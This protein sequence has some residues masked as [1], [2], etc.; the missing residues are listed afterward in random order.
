MVEPPRARSPLPDLG[1]IVEHRADQAGI[2]DAAMA[3]EGPV[4]GGEEGVDQLRRKFLVG[5]LDPPLAGE[6]SGT[7]SPLTSRT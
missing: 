1:D 2:V 4:L 6:A 7:G 5:E 3:E